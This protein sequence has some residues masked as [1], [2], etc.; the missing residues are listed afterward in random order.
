MPEQL[1]F[2]QAWGDRPTVHRHE[3]PFPAA[4]KAVDAARNQ[5]LARAR[6]PEDEDARVGRRDLL[7]LA[8][9]GRERGTS[10]DEVF[11]PLLCLDLFMQVDVL[12]L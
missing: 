5:L 2:H 11:E 12:G 7:H 9:H 8:E 3:R 6:F 1:A 4:A 10:A